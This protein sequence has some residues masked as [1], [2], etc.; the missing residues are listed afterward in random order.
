VNFPVRFI[1]PIFLEGNFPVRQLSGW[2][3]NFPVQSPRT[4]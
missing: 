4:V 3:V 2:S 1:W